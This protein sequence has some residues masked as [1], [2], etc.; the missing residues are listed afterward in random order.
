METRY[1]CTLVRICFKMNVRTGVNHDDIDIEHEQKIF[2]ELVSWYCP[3]WFARSFPHNPEDLPKGVFPEQHF[4][5]W[6]KKK[7]ACLCVGYYFDSDI[8][9]DTRKFK[10][11][12]NKVIENARVQFAD[13]W[14]E[15]FEQRDF[16][17]GRKEYS[18][19][20]QSQVVSIFVP[21]Q[22]H[23]NFL[24]K[25]ESVEEIE[26]IEWMLYYDNDA[27]NIVYNKKNHEKN[28]KSAKDHP[29][30]GNELLKIY[31]F[32]EK[33]KQHFFVPGW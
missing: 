22:C 16:K 21:V 25:W 4:I 23:E 24:A 19:Q 20:V 5:T 17:I 32:I 31:E 27:F 28:V 26:N 3:T 33:N 10:D 18:P 7:G 2:H 9:D 8:L 15:G 29:L 30:R 1:D 12:L 13:G 6:D 14:G 11:V